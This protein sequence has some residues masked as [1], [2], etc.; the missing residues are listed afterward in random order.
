MSDCEVEYA[1]SYSS[2]CMQMLISR[3]KKE[4][5]HVNTLQGGNAKIKKIKEYIL[6]LFPED[7]CFSL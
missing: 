2:S 1:A 7:V 4:P 3:V 6:S 5:K